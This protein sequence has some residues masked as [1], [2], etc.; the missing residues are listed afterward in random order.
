MRNNPTFAAMG[1]FKILIHISVAIWKPPLTILL[2]LL[3]IAGDRFLMR[4]D[5]R[6]S[7]RP[8]TAGTSVADR[9]PAPLEALVPAGLLQSVVAI[10]SH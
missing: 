1:D 7:Q 10:P 5:R 6:A 8:H 3:W 4:V 2:W 9:V